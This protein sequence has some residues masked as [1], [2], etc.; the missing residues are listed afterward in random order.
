M[1]RQ[2][3]NII[4]LDNARRSASSRSFADSRSSYG[5]SS[6][7]ARRASGSDAF[8]SVDAFDDLVPFESPFAASRSGARGA[9]GRQAYSDRAPR[10]RTSSSLEFST[11]SRSGRISKPIPSW[12]DAE[13]SHEP[14]RRSSRVSAR[15]GARSEAFDAAPRSAI[16]SYDEFEE[17]EQEAHGAASRAGK[18]KRKLKEKAEKMFARQ[19]GGS[20]GASEA[21][22]RAAVYKGE[23]GKSHK[24]AFA[25]M[26]GTQRGSRTSAQAG[27]GKAKKM[28]SKT[29][30][31]IAVAVG[32]LVCAAA[33]VLFLYPTAKQV[34]V[35]SREEDRLQAEYNALLARNEAM[36]DRIDYLKT[37]E[38][39][40][41]AARQQLGWVKE[42]EKAVVVEGLSDDSLDDGSAVNVQIMSGSIP[43]P[44]TWYSPVLD[45]V[46][47]YSDPA[48]AQK[49]DQGN[50]G[51]GD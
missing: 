27:V 25:E 50:A 9:S 7:R 41:D 16:E 6:S 15:G 5:A 3:G 22:P 24:R 4:S 28:K 2:G 13:D 49:T 40:Q 8:A 20:D 31:R 11:I 48:T 44:E 47:G 42:G 37:D 32:C 45:V 35:E 21:G 33:V 51:S 38:G 39:I 12:Y 23:M 14:S 34:Y 18:K 29:A 17:A 36:Q 1:A 10:P 30:S 26:G 19:F 46:F 43:A